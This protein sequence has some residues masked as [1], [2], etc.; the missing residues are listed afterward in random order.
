MGDGSASWDLTESGGGSSGVSK[1]IAGTNV[2][3]SPSG[4][5][6]NVTINASGGGGGGVSSFNTRTGAV[7]LSNADV[8]TILAAFTGTAGVSIID[9]T[10]DGI[11][12]EDAGGGG[13]QLITTGEMVLTA[14]GANG[15]EVAS[16]ANGFGL[17]TAANLAGLPTPGSAPAFGFTQDGHI[18]FYAAPSGPWSLVAPSSGGAGVTSFNT[19]SGAV[20]LAAAD[21]ESTFGA[22]GQLFAGTGAGTGDLVATGTAGQVLTV[23]GADP[24]GLEWATPAGGSV[25]PGQYTTSTITADPAPAVVGT[26]YRLNYSGTFTLPSSGLAS[27]DW[28]RVKQIGANQVVTIVGTVDGAT[29]F[30]IANQYDA[31]EFIYNGSTWDIN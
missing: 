2:T 16:S 26:Y 27:G 6:G 28:V 31:Y 9:S 21:V 29:G 8:A 30:Y 25:V 14:S 17:F 11:T 3:I 13:L 1:I 7:T 15:I 5:T 20:V 12:I 23:G 24:S 10:G 4:G 18:Y 22:K 19:R